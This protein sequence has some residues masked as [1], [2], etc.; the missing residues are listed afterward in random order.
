MVDHYAMFCRAPPHRGVCLTHHGCIHRGQKASTPETNT[1]TPEADASIPKQATL[2]IL[3]FDE[4]DAR[5]DELAT[6]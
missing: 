4:A 2:E 1:S 6:P 3:D 5:L